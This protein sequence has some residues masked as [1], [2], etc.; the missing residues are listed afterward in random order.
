MIRRTIKIVEEIS[1]ISGKQRPKEELIANRAIPLEPKMM[2]RLGYSYSGETALHLT[3][4]VHLNG[5]YRI[6][7]TN[8]QLSTF[9]RGGPE[10]VRL[11]SQPNCM[12]ELIGTE[13]IRGKSDLWTT[14]DKTG[15]RWINHNVAERSTNFKL[16]FMIDGVIT[17]LLK[18]YGIDF[19]TEQQPSS[20]VLKVINTLKDK[21]KFIK[22]YFLSIEKWIDDGGYKE[23]QKYLDNSANL[24]YNEI[25][26]SKFKIKGV[27]A[28]GI[29]NPAVDNFCEKHN[30]ENR[31]VISSESLGH[32]QI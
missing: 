7:G 22:D 21:K 5:L 17:K 9:S 8:A 23:F 19:S 27:Y 30:I 13:I 31:G 29:E 14:V 15:M 10:L 2:K 4:S 11:P 18:K 1:K 28:I 32:I 12:V 24:K 3:N 6:Q 26:L 16:T 20:E 25:V